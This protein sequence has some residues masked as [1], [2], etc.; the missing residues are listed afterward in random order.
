MSDASMK[1]R[2][3]ATRGTCCDER[4][5]V[6]L[7]SLALME[8]P[9][10]TAPL[11]HSSL[12]AMCVEPPTRW[13][14]RRRRGEET[15]LSTDDDTRSV[16]SSQ[17]QPDAADVEMMHSLSL[18]EALP[19]G[20]LRLGQ[21]HGGRGHG[22]RAAKR[23][24][25][26]DLGPGGLGGGLGIEGLVAS[27]QGNGG[28]PSSMGASGSSS[29]LDASTM[30][31]EV[32]ILAPADEHTGNALLCFLSPDTFVGFVE[33]EHEGQR[34]VL[35]LTG[36][37]SLTECDRALCNVQD[38]C[39][40]KAFLVTAQT[41]TQ[42]R[43]KRTYL[44]RSSG[45]GDYVAFEGRGMRFLTDFVPGD[46]QRDQVLRRH[47]GMLPRSAR[48]ESVLCLGQMTIHWRGLGRAG[49]AE[50]ASHEAA[51]SLVA[52]ERAHHEGY[53]GDK[54]EAES[55]GDEAATAHELRASMRSILPK[56]ASV[57]MPTP[58]PSAFNVDE[59]IER[60]GVPIDDLPHD[61][62]L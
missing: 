59:L 20:Q 2:A 22:R 27:G 40:D 54:S 36:S 52:D 17:W 9:P 4:S 37:E 10:P 43:R 42:A 35:K 53:A 55:S 50:A 14:R 58:H 8:P 6:L 23:L 5:L 25:V 7:A 39:G 31:A 51:A 21:M 12:G 26:V 49:E 32:P 11:T 62:W 46:E 18:V 56:L 57:A 41:C 30:F 28:G 44:A 33:L 45:V 24:K 48:R 16:V 29:T 3:V 34:H 19:V 1:T 13:R 47:F 38:C 61:D 15:T 60:G